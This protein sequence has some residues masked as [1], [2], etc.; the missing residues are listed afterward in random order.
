M[1]A[2]SFPAILPKVTAPL[3]LIVSAPFIGL[4]VF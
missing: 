4:A 3:V 2:T 1:P